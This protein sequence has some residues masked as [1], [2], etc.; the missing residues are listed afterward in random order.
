MRTY[1]GRI[2]GMQV[3][4]HVARGNRQC[5]DRLADDA[6]DLGGIRLE[7]APHDLARERHRKQQQFVLH[8]L[9][10]LV[11]RLGEIVEHAG[12][13]LDLR[14]HLLVTGRAPLRKTLFERFFVGF[15]LEIGETAGRCERI[16]R[17]AMAH[18]R[19]RPDLDARR[20]LG[21]E[22]RHSRRHPC[23]PD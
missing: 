15:G 14:L 21:C 1:D 5:R 6:D 9:I 16:L 7:F 23:R 19:R 17:R 4:A 10:E 3:H 2:L 22:L 18:V 13:P 11:E 20:R 12:K 8:L